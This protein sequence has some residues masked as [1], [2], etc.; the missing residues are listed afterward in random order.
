MGISCLL[1][2]D[3]VQAPLPVTCMAFANG[4]TLPGLAAPSFGSAP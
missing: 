4:A 3:E 1:A 2:A